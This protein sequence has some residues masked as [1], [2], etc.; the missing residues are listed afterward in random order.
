MGGYTRKGVLYQGPTKKRGRPSSKKAIVVATVPTAPKPVAQNVKNYVKKSINREIETKTATINIFNQ[1]ATLGYGLNS[2]T[3]LG[4]TNSL[5]IIPTLLQSDEQSGRVGN[6]VR[7][8]ALYLRFSLRAIQTT[9]LGVNDNPFMPFIVRVICYSKKLS[10]TDFTNTGI[11]QQ[12]NTSV[13]LGSA[14]E[15]WLEPYNK[16]VF[17]IHYSKQYMMIPHRKVTNNAAPNNYAQ[18]AIVEGAKS[19]IM[20]R[21]KLKGIPKTF[22]YDDAAGGTNAN[23]PTNA[24]VF[25]AV[26]VCNVDG[27][28]GG[29]LISDQRVQVNADSFLY[30]KDA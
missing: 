9:Y 27:T 4:L 3:N 16:D 1:Q 12:G 13:N 11:L 25:M 19:F 22:I 10:R 21:V 28:A 17:N 18:D 6:K 8:T 5:S 26:C 24:S 20:K 2:S 7:P 23:R 14:P 30:Y 15:T 29:S